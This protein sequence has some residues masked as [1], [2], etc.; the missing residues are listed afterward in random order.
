VYISNSEREIRIDHHIAEA[1]EAEDKMWLEVE[2]L[3]AVFASVR[4]QEKARW[5]LER[6]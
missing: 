4:A 3:I 1:E 2:E 5:I 6:E